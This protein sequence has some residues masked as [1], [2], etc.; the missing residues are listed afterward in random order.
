MWFNWK[1]RN[2]MA[3]GLWISKL[4]KIVVPAERAKTVTIPRSARA[5]PSKGLSQLRPESKPPP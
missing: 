5:L 1:G 3:M 2:S 4:P